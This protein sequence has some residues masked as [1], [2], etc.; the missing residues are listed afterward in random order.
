MH[1]SA[2]DTVSRRSRSPRSCSRS[3][4]SASIELLDVLS[5]G[6]H[7]CAARPRPPRSPAPTAPLLQRGMGNAGFGRITMA[8]S[9]PVLQPHLPGF[10]CL[11]SRAEALAQSSRPTDSRPTSPLGRPASPTSLAPRSPRSPPITAF[12]ASGPTGDS[13]CSASPTRPSAKSSFAEEPQTTS[14]RVTGIP[15]RPQFAAALRCRC[16]PRAA[17][18]RSGPPSRLGARR[19]DA[20]RP[21]REVQGL[22]RGHAAGDRLGARHDRRRRDRPRRQLRRRTPLASRRLRHHQRPGAGLRGADGRS[23]VGRRRR[24]L[25]AGR[26]RHRRVRRGRTPHGAGRTRPS[27]RSA[28]TPSRCWPRARRSTTTTLGGSPRS[29]GAR[30]AIPASSSRCA[31]RRSALL[32][33]A[34]RTRLS[35]SE[36]PGFSASAPRRAVRPMRTRGRR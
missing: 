17:R 16:R 32:A 36:S 31:R 1:R 21:L 35:P 11:D 13:T 34:R 15:V 20:A 8:A 26:P 25:Q 6:S 2:R 29:S 10:H 9:G 4:L 23:H 27:A 12:T 3:S 5:F 19:C 30:W 24:R 7:I 18:L 22:A 28:P 14:I 33:P